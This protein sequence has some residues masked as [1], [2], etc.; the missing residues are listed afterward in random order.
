MKNQQLEKYDPKIVHI[1]DVIE[2]EE[3][4]MGLNSQ[5][6]LENHVKGEQPMIISSHDLRYRM[7]PETFVPK[8]SW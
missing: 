7:Q 2:W 4:E 5:Y 6:H 8:S 1:D 3:C